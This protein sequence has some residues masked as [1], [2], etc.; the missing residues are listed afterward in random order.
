M[1]YLDHLKQYLAS[2]NHGYI[3]PSHDEYQSEYV[4]IKMLEY[5]TGF[6]GSYGIAIIYPEHLE[7]K[8]LFFTDGRYITQAKIQL[9]SKEFD[10]FNIKDL[11]NSKQLPQHKLL[12]NPKFFTENQLKIFGTSIEPAT[13]DLAE[14]ILSQHAPHLLSKP[15]TPFWNYP[16]EYSGRS[17]SDKHKDLEQLWE[18]TDYI[19]ITK[20]DSIS[21][22]LNIR[23]SDVD[24]N[25]ITQ[26]YLIISPSS[27]A[28]FTDCNKINQLKNMEN[29]IFSSIESITEYIADISNKRILCDSKSTSVYFTNLFIQNHLSIIYAADPISIIKSI[30]NSTELK[31]AIDVHKRDGIAVE[32]LLSWIKNNLGKIYESDV[33]I[34]LEELRKQQPG[35]IMSSFPTICGYKEN[36]AIIHYRAQKGKDKLIEAESLLLIDSGGQYL[37]CTTDITRTIALG[38]P[39]IEQKTRYTQ[40]LKGHISLMLIY[41]PI[42]TRG[43]QLDALARQY[44]WMDG[45][46]YAHGTGHGVGSCL[47]VHEGPQS[48]ST[49]HS[50]ILKEGMILSN[51]PGFYKEGEFGIRIENLVYVKQSEYP[52]YLKFE[53]LTLVSYDENLIAYDLLSSAE[54]NFL[55]HYNDLIEDN[56][57]RYTI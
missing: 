41:F 27:I 33:A 12:Y 9:D 25:P 18:T 26:G 46:N 40:V 17:L 8:S 16:I 42:G 47:S 1:M 10:I 37:G 22:F 11:S 21:W 44:L 36:G 53:N 2:T 54:K 19:F 28:F 7:Q 23:G 43:D 15:E 24:Y 5:I 13:N 4:N 20:S 56:K 51:E 38:Y 29:V 14:E 39:S 50:V 45:Q 55:K 48:I 6:S 49:A 32:L 31:H 30:K 3:I 52:G 35:F 57:L 34:K